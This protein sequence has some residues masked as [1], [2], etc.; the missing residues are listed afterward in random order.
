MLLSPAQKSAATWGA[1]AL[2]L[3]LLMWLLAPVLTPFVTAAVLAYALT[4]LVNRLDAAWGGRLPRLLAVLAVELVFLLTLLGFLLLVAP[5]LVKELPL[6]REHIPQLLERFVAWLQPMLAQLGIE[7]S[8]DLASLKPMILNYLNANYEE[9]LLPLLSSIKIGGSVALAVL[10]NLVLIPL[11]LFFLL[12]DWK[13]FVGRSLDLVPPRLRPGFDSFA[14]EADAV[15][16]QYLRGQFLVM[17]I[18]A[19]YYSVG[20][21][22]FGLDLALPIGVFTGLAIFVPYIGFGLGLLLAA[23][24]GFLQFQLAGTVLLMLL[25]VYGL[26]QLIESLLLT[27]RLVGERIGLHPLAV[28]FVLLAFGQLFGFVGVLVALP[29]SAVLLVAIRRLRTHY[30]KSG[31]YLS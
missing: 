7:A 25:L 26:G 22:L 27:P 1:V 17:L 4:P 31:F 3:A 20:L 29:T 8:L 13:D 9:A 6:L 14:K 5:I 23:M 18:L 30:L 12:L 21:S 19:V 10:G 28:I 11:A 15:L 24:A 16:G 2:A